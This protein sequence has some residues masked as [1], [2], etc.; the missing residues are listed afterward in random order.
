MT[1]KK[2]ISYVKTTSLVP[3]NASPCASDEVL[4]GIL[5]GRHA[6]SITATEDVYLGDENV[7]SSTGLTIPAGETMTFPVN[8]NIKKPFYVVG[9]AC[10]IT[11][12][13]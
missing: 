11:E 3:S 5:L 9:G 8:E 13:F 10:V 4:G 7:T 6:I 12:Y 1:F 2:P